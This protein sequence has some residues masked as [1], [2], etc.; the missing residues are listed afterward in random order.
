M[1]K[2][3]W[4]QTFDQAPKLITHPASSAAAAAM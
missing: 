4:V 1:L 3:S 2:A